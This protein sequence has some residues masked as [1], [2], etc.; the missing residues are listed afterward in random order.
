MPYKRRAR[1]LVVGRDGADPR[2]RWVVER[3]AQ[4]DAQ[5][6]LEARVAPAGGADD[7][8]WPALT[9]WADLLVTVD[10]A[11]AARAGRWPRA[12]TC[13]LKR[14][15]LPWPADAEGAPAD[16]TVVAAI[17]EALACMV[18]GMRLLSRLD[19]DEGHD[20]R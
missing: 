9:Q 17:D 12:A 3:A 18:G 4:P 16:A 19:A 8:A 20:D 15:R 14:W 11:A 2:P 1:L 10:E 13:R 7:P 6:W 5:A